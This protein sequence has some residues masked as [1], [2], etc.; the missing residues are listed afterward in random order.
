MKYISRKNNKEGL[1]LSKTKQE[2]VSLKIKSFSIDGLSTV[3]SFITKNWWKSG[4]NTVSNK[5][6]G[7]LLP[8]REAVEVKAPK[9][10]KS[11]SG[12][13]NILAELVQTN[14]G[15]LIDDMPP[16]CYKIWKLGECSTPWTHSLM[17]T[18]PK[19]GNLQQCQNCRTVSFIR[20]P[21]KVLLKQDLYHI[22]IDFKRAFK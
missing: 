8:V 17:V 6:R 3:L 10:A 13:D 16:I 5:Y 21:S 14:R 18:L 11:S 9:K 22:F 12:V 1:P 19:K 15:T 7:G 2:N 20:H 4:S